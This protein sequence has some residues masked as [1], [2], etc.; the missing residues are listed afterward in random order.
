MPKN[1]TPDTTVEVET[2]NVEF[3]AK[4]SRK[5]LIIGSA[6]AGALSVA[7]LSALKNRSRNAEILVLE[8]T[9][10]TTDEV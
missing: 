1:E 5:A 2:P 3:K 9:D 10:V 8:P 4:V 6:V 7:V